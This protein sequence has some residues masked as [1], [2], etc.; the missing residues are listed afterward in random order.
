[1]SSDDETDITQA[2]LKQL[3]SGEVP[4]LIPEQIDIELQLWRKIKARREQ[5]QK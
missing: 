1:M 3:W 5:E 2:E 4:P